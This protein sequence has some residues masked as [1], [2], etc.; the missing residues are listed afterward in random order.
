MKRDFAGVWPNTP[1]YA[2]GKGTA[3]NIYVTAAKLGIF[4]KTGGNIKGCVRNVGLSYPT[5]W[6]N[7]Y[8]EYSYQGAIAVNENIYRCLS[9]MVTWNVT[10]L[11]SISKG[12]WS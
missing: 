11:V 4:W 8:I 6:M 2:A 9:D 1:L 10:I 7:V 5:N 3:N 12:N